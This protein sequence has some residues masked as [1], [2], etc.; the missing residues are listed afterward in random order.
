[1][2][3]C[4]PSTEIL[5][6]ALQASHQQHRLLSSFHGGSFGSGSSRSRAHQGSQRHRKDSSD[7]CV[8][9]CMCVCVCVCVHPLISIS[10]SR[11]C[12]SSGR[13]RK[14]FSNWCVCVCV[15]VCLCACACACVCVCV[16]VYPL[17]SISSS[18]ACQSS[19]RQRKD[20]SVW[21]VCAPVHSSFHWNQ[22]QST[23]GL[24]GSVRIPLT[25]VRVRV[26]VCVCVCVRV[27]VCAC[28]YGYF[29][30][31]FFS[32]CNFCLKSS[33]YHKE[34]NINTF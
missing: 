30:G 16:C 22:Q 4:R 29:P 9:V 8:R 18:R 17:I 6:N 32:L 24:A 20:S 1:V 5:P 33:L 28:V 7:W 15:C 21:C 10:S 31:L 3:L 23:P 13:Q 14:G 2:C 34:Q 26:C 27:C 25:G 12:Q 11:A 19:G